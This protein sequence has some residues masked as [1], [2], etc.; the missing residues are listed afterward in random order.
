MNN[1]VAIIQA[2]NGSSR[3]PGKVLL[4]LNGYTVLEQIVRRV[5]SSRAIQEVFVATTL[6]EEDIKIVKICALKGIR[7]FC[8]SEN[9]V[10]D[11][12]YQLAKLVKPKHIVRITADC[13]LID[14]RIIDH[15]VRFY[16]YHKADYVS[17]A[18]KET[19]PDGEDIEVF[20]FSSL[21][22][23]WEKA[24]LC[25]E[26]EHVTPFI[27]KN[28]RIFKIRNFAYKK[29]LSGKR[30]TLDYPLD[31]KFIKMVYKYLYP[32]NPLFGMNH[33]LDLLSKRPEIERINQHYVRNSEYQ[34]LL[35]KDKLD[36][37]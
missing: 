16:L 7:I 36:N 37:D 17:N 23:A 15:V 25:S 35:K 18:I 33:V 6:K 28:H 13:P 10:L 2:R 22:L 26:R 31:Y 20:S 30:W 8:G 21:K 14:P 29:D 1:V 9:D 27:R 11:R 32:I 12:Y 3:L 34:E 4:D 24:N 5:K 19:F